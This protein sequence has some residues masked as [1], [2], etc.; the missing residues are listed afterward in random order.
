[1]EIKR[2]QTLATEIYKTKN[3]IN[4]SLMKN[5]LTRKTNANIRPHDIILRYHNTAT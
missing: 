5:I 1:M 4:P 2:L 3:N